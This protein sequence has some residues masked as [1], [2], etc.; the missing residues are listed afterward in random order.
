M[1]ELD[2]PSSPFENLDI[3]ERGSKTL[4]ILATSQP[5][6]VCSASYPLYV[7]N[8][9]PIMCEVKLLF[10]NDYK[11]PIF[12][13]KEH[14]KDSGSCG[15]AQP[16]LHCRMHAVGG[17]GR[18]KAAASPGTSSFKKQDPRISFVWRHF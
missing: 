6:K 9:I 14:L 1:S 16:S 12:Q 3:R 2:H 18:A 7:D 4:P 8:K 11:F 13:L 17:V 10:K 5:L 15:K